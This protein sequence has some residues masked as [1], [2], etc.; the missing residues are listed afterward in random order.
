MKNVIL[1]ISLFV[2]GLISI[3]AFAQIKTPAPSP[4][5]K[6]EQTVGLTDVHVEY[7][8]PSMKG[9]T[10]F[11]ADGLVPFGK[12]WRT[13][14]NQATKVT[15]T[16]DVQIEGKDLE[17]GSYALFSTPGATS[18]DVH[19]FE[20]TTNSAGGYGEA[21]PTLT[22]TV[23]PETLPL[24]ME[25]FE[26][27]VGDLT[28]NG[29]TLNLLWSNVMVPMQLAVHTE[30]QAMASI[31]KTLAGPSDSDYYNA[32]VYMA[33]SGKEL[34]KALGYI[35]KVT[36]G[37]NQRYWQLRQEAE[38]LAKLG[39]HKEAVTVAKKSMSLATEAGNND[40]IKINKDNIAKW[41]MK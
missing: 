17:K 7:S 16:E 19:F 29:A 9:R 23:T 27:F 4:S 5:A 33:S 12:R 32:G 18:W 14:A 11:A 10:I 26:I 40:Y 39:K 13:G 25:S 34:D 41:S 38:V 1:L 2:A 35:Q 21:T 3:D 20:H 6:I 22:V 30:K 15:F 8:R 24:E 31:E 36:H 28:A 37:E